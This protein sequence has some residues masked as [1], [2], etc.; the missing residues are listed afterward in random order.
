MKK[1]IAAAK[2]LND[3]L[4]LNPPIKTTSIK[5]D[6]LKELLLEAAENLV[7]E[8]EEDVSEATVKALKSIDAKIP[9]LEDEDKDVEEIEDIEGMED[10]D[11]DDD[12]DDDEDDQ[13]DDEVE[14]IKTESVPEKKS[15]K[16][17]EKPKKADKPTKEEKADK[18]TKE[19]KIDKPKGK[20]PE[21]AK[22]KSGKGI[23]ATIVSLLEKATK[24]QPITKAEI[25]DVLK[26]EFPDRDV[27][28]MTRTVHVQVPGRISREKFKLGV[29]EDGKGF[30]K[31]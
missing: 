2:E 21:K 6:K 18:P 26:K 13:D 5:E 14:E 23:I 12:Q 16:K 29:T 7:A 9:W 10:E 20:K 11:V 19:E 31:A 24:K 28:G 17:E 3:L 30:Y 22:G 4:G 8:D 25:I 15:A 1:L 27:R